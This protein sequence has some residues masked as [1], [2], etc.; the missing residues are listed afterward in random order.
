MG[1]LAEYVQKRWGVKTHSIENPVTKD[2]AAGV[3]R[4]LLNNPDRFEAIVV[5]YDT[6]LMRLAPTRNVSATLGIPLEP[7]GG[8]AVI[9]A[10]DDGESVGYEWF[11]WTETGGTDNI[12]VLVTEAS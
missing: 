7:A 3:T 6:K 5:N 9:T 1:A 12:Y 8:F 10:D 11:V 4:I 2:A